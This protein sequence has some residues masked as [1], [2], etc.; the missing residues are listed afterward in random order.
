MTREQI[1]A[2]K[3]VL[4]L[5]VNTDRSY[6]AG[7]SVY[8][9]PTTGTPTYIEIRLRHWHTHALIKTWVVWNKGAR[10]LD[11]LGVIPRGYGKPDLAKVAE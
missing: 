7:V 6:R 5:F 3:H 9:Y 8:F 10:P 1:I 2:C 11:F 4:D